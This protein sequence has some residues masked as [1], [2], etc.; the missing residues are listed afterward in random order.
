MMIGHNAESHVK[1]LENSLFL[2][3]TWTTDIASK[4]TQGHYN[5]VFI[6]ENNSLEDR[7]LLVA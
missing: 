5:E 3:W 7:D 2:M 4:Q 1:Q 6:D